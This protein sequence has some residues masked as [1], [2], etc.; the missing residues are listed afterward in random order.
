MAI[1]AAAMAAMPAL[2]AE[3]GEADYARVSAGIIEGHV[4]PRMQAFERATGRLDAAVTHACAGGK[5]QSAPNALIER[6]HETM[7]AWMALRHLSFGPAEDFMRESR[8]QFAPDPDGR[9]AAAVAQLLRSDR[10]GEIDPKAFAQQSVA[11]QGLPALEHVLFAGDGRPALTAGGDGAA[12]CRLGRAITRNLKTMAGA[13]AAEWRDPKGI[14]HRL[15]HPGEKNVF[16]ST[17]KDATLAF[18][19]A[20]HGGFDVL[21]ALKI[22]PPLGKS[23]ATARPDLVES[24]RS[25]RSAR[26]IVIN[27]EA[28]AALYH[29]EGGKP[30]LGALLHGAKGDPKIASLM[31][32]AFDQTI[33]TARAIAPSLARAVADPKQRPQVEKLHLQVRALRQIIS[34]RLAP[35]MGI[36]GGFNALDGD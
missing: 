36:A 20:L 35:A 1:A 27:L 3:P 11:A 25:K 21:A 9:V 12:R 17:H 14:A 31:R 33:A 8:I 16:F 2:A 19:K 18:S 4:L 23:L 29:G 26:N 10:G 5:P 34:E 6:F 22:E 24:A 7:D 28:L 32:R 15:T 13:M 30:G